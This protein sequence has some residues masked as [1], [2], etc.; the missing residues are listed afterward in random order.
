[1]PIQLLP[2]VLINQI[3]AGEVVERPAAVVKELVE[4]ALD[5]GARRL[6]VEL[7]QGGLRRILV[8]DDGKGIAR[9]ELRLAL[10]RHAT[11]KIAS[12]DDLER[13]ESL[14]FRG[15]ALASI[16][17][18]S[19]LMLSSRTATD[20]H[21]W[22]LGGEGDLAGGE[23]VP[24]AQ[25]QGTAV[26]V[27]DLFFSTP[28]RRKFMKSPSTEARHVETALRRLALARPEIA[29]SLHHDGRRLLQLEPA[30]DELS[31]KQRL[32]AVC[33]AEFVANAVYREAEVGGLRLQGWI[34]LPS[35]SRSQPDLQF[36][37]VNGRG[38]RDRLLGSALRRA[39]A[40]ALHS[41][42]HP[43]FVLAL[44]LDPAAVDVNV[45]PQK[46]EVR[47]R[48]GARVHDFLFGLVHRWLRELRPEPEQHHAVGFGASMESASYA[49]PLRTASSGIAETRPVYPMPRAAPTWTDLVAATPNFAT[50]ATNPAPRPAI[51]HP[52]G[53]AIAQLH[54]LFV[55]AQ[56]ARGLVLVDMHAAHERVIY[57]RYKRELAQGGVPSQAL[58]APILVQ[59][60]EDEAELAER[61]SET[62]R[63]AGLLVDRAGPGQL[64]VRGTPTLLPTEAVVELLKDL[65]GRSSDSGSHAHLGEVL[66]AQHRVLADMACK[67]AI[68]ANRSL[69]LGEMNALLRDMESTDL[70]GQCNHGRPTWVQIELAELDRLFLRGR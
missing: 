49:L 21:G 12:L 37:T 61:Q 24:A 30:L 54:G 44:T 25:A 48:E 58:L 29:F 9:D 40:D 68:K 69:N 51:E 22:R 13:V 63:A 8:R 2:E 50:A 66:D 15:E 67:A 65:L 35:F 34:A 55:L 70:A 60:G 57:E 19:R 38:V 53:Y 4:N 28:A 43:A 56:N 36:L 17:A 3:K 42:R 11:S 64:L 23:P 31:R 59:V 52:L 18:V 26:E 20:G 10:S 1:M 27:L 16:L 7:E 39:Y 62:L 6:V 46:T 14:G 32:T 45:H 5:A 47:F 33:G 41:T